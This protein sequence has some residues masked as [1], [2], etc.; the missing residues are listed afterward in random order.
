MHLVGRQEKL[1]LDPLGEPFSDAVSKLLRPRV[2]GDRLLSP[3]RA[4]RCQQDH[5]RETKPSDRHQPSNPASA[6]A[7]S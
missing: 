3:E 1:G 7:R 4:R 5:D 2:G 6:R